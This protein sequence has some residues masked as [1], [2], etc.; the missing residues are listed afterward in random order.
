MSIR[1]SIMISSGEN[2]LIRVGIMALE[3]IL[4]LFN[5]TAGIIAAMNLFN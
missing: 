3:G 2:T 4:F 5:F 1:A